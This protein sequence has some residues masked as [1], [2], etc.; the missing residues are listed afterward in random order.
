MRVDCVREEDMGAEIIPDKGREF[1]GPIGINVCE[2]LG[3][4]PLLCSTAGYSF[5]GMAS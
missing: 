3:I 2:L 4:V 5:S 1:K